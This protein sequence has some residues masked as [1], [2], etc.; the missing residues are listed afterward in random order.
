MSIAN[1]LMATQVEITEQRRNNPPAAKPPSPTQ[2]KIHEV[3]A[4]RDAMQ[5]EMDSYKARSPAAVAAELA[6]AREEKEALKQQLK[7]A[8]EKQE[9]QKPFVVPEGV[10]GVLAQIMKK[11]MEIQE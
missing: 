5:A 6:T 2:L 7:L 4:K 3:L 10:T 1:R 9:E 11:Q 8:T